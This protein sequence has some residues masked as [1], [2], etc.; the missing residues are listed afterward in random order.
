MKVLLDSCVWGK[1]SEEL[2]ALGHDVIWSGSWPKDP[3][4]TEILR[5]AYE[6]RRVVITLDK[7]FGERALLKGQPHAG[8]IRLVNIPAK[9]QARYAAQILQKHAEELKLGAIITADRQ[10]IRVRHHD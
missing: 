9:E 2:S 8:I 7:D 3:S 1:A 6:Q 10:R 5:I 4:D